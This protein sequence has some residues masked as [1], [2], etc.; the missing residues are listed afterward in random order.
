MLREI[1]DYLA[2]FDKVS[3]SLTSKTCRAKLGAF[4]CP[5]YLS[6]AAYL[7]LNAHIYPSWQQ[8]Y[9]L[10]NFDLALHNVYTHIM[11]QSSPPLGEGVLK[12]FQM[13]DFQLSLYYSSFKEQE[14]FEDP[15]VGG[16]RLEKPTRPNCSNLEKPTWPS[17]SNPS[18]GSFKPEMFLRPYFPGLEY[19][20]NT[21]ANLY[22]RRFMDILEAAYRRKES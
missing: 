19:P 16:L 7:C 21:L 2:F 14:W 17:S 5:D 20:E 11:Q 15:N 4:N 9:L 18:R 13:L 3:L 12:K 10:P 8:I 6:W 1:G 22:L